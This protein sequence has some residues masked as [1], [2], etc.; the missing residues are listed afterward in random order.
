MS[1]AMILRVLGCWKKSN[2]I[3]CNLTLII[4]VNKQHMYDEINASIEELTS[5]PVARQ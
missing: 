2:A 4:I 1:L 3:N 5:H